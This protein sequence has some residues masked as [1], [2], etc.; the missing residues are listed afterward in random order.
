MHPRFTRPPD[1]RPPPFPPFWW[2]RPLAKP[3][4]R[5][6]H[7]VMPCSHCLDP[8][9]AWLRPKFPFPRQPWRWETE[10]RAPGTGL[11]WGPPRQRCRCQR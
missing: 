10:S 9:Y 11:I 6:P 1:F 2:Q 5:H 7:Y 8:P 4:P 3:A